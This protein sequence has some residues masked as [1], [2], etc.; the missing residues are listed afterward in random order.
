MSHVR[1]EVNQYN[2][3]YNGIVWRR[4]PFPLIIFTSQRDKTF[5]T[6]INR[7]K[8]AEKLTRFNGIV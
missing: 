7:Q 4:F 6:L 3:H 2:R 1:G 5:F 8:Y